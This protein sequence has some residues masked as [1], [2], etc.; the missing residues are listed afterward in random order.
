MCDA[1]H[2]AANAVRETVESQDYSSNADAGSACRTPLRHPANQFN[3]LVRLQLPPGSHG[4]TAPL[5]WP[6]DIPV[7]LRKIPLSRYS[8]LALK[9][10]GVAPI[11]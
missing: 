6:N 3:L 7:L 1:G 4:T 10:N 11:L 2:R 8:A 9:R 5:A